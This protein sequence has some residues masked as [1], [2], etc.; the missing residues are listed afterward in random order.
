MIYS[1]PSS[2]L[3]C[4][5]RRRKCYARTCRCSSPFHAHAR[6]FFLSLQG[7]LRKGEMVHARCKLRSNPLWLHNRLP[8]AAFV[9]WQHPHCCATITPEANVR[10][11]M[12]SEHSI[13]LQRAIEIRRDFIFAPGDVGSISWHITSCN[14][15]LHSS[16]IPVGRYAQ[17]EVS[18]GTVSIVYA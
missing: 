15:E 17:M 3:S 12:S 16:S 9:A 4:A 5:K 10:I 8:D 14:W 6:A 7:F 2:I 11:D 13:R 1:I 18:F